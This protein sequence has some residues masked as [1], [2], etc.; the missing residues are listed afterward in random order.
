MNATEEKW[1]TESRTLQVELPPEGWRLE[2]GK[3]LPVLEICYETYGTLNEAG[4]NAILICAPLT[5]DAHAAGWHS[6]ADKNPGWWDPMIGPGKAI[7]TNRYF[8]ICSNNL[9]GC[10]GTTGP[11][12]TN[13]QTGKAFGSEFPHITIGDMVR[14]QKCLVDHL[15]VKKLFAA[16]GGSMGGLE[17]LKWAI[18]FPDFLEKS[19]VIAATTQLS[20][21][22]LGFEILG[23][24]AITADPG[25]HGGDYYEQGQPAQGLALARKIAHITYLS[26]HSMER[27]FSRSENGQARPAEF[28]TAF[29]VESYLDHQGAKFVGRFDAN[30]YLHITWAMDHFDL[31][32]DYGS[33]EEAFSRVKCH[34][35]NVNLSSDWLFPPEESRRITAAVVNSGGIITNVELDSPYGHD[36]FLLEVRHLSEVIQRFLNTDREISEQESINEYRSSRN[37]KL[38]RSLVEPGC[39]VLDIGCGDGRL[40]D[41]LWQDKRVNGVGID[42]DFYKVLSCIEKNVPVLQFDLNEGLP[43]I[44]DDTF[45]TVI[46]NRT[47]EQVQKPRELLQEL[48]RTSCSAIVAFPNFAN[49][50]NRWSLALLG[51][52]PRNPDL[53]FEWYDTPNIHL[54]TLDDFSRLCREDHL[55]IDEVHVLNQSWFSRLLCRL[56]LRNA[57]AETVVVKIN[58]DCDRCNKKVRSKLTSC[59]QEG[60]DA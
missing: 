56:G 11:R 1:Y 28:R 12:S 31:A 29:E 7:D 36:A 15:G 43:L 55:R 33:I 58:R 48:M 21:Q 50:R 9:G 51:R 52:M 19:A 3:T 14:V 47:L 27:K 26:P 49:W 46:L 18:E 30:T 20:S 5:A 53:P 24:Q 4:D 35:L 34:M 41:L 40:I 42:R 54:F 16:L 23:R 8:V 32:K 60:T 2:S 45:D 25:F 39:R 57:G 10:Q 6:A 22:A 17:A 44:G 37:Y 59:R 13:P 38:L